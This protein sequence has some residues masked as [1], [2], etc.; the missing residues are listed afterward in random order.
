MALWLASCAAQNAVPEET[1]APA[2]AS[3]RQTLA[4]PVSGPG[5]LFVLKADGTPFKDEKGIY[6]GEIKVEPY[7]S[8]LDFMAI[9][10]TLGAE[11]RFAIAVELPYIDA[12]HNIS[13]D[14]PAVGLEVDGFTL[15]EGEAV[16]SVI[17]TFSR[18]KDR[19]SRVTFNLLPNGLERLRA[20]KERVAVKVRLRSDAFA[21][22]GECV[23][24]TPG[25]APASGC[26]KP[27]IGRTIEGAALKKLKDFIGTA[28]AEQGSG[29][30]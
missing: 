7:T 26:R 4:F 30:N 23:R 19:A 17:S 2:V 8:R 21:S 12:S 1:A 10:T 14:R 24:A 3:V 6:K 9:S 28:T 16:D 25:S 15:R 11:R 29:V 27:Y 20:A 22:A 5:D 18:S 13:D